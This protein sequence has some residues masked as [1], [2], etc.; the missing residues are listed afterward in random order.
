MTPSQIEPAVGE[1]YRRR[2]TRQTVLLLRR[3]PRNCWV[4]IAN[5]N[6]LV[7]WI[8]EDQLWDLYIHA[9]SNPA[10]DD[11]NGRE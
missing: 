6:G 8:T 2:K 11:L 9:A 4:E 1:R 10:W 5:E 7:W 3:N